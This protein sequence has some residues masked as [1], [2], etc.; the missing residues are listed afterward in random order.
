MSYRD[1]IVLPFNKLQMTVSDM[2][3]AAESLDTILRHYNRLNASVEAT[4]PAED[5]AAAEVSAQNDLWWIISSIA[6]NYIRFQ[7]RE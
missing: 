3:T 2:N 7:E 4:V 6:D 1:K 5:R